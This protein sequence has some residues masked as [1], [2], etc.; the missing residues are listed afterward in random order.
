MVLA[1]YEIR[2]IVYK[3]SG[4]NSQHQPTKKKK[5]ITIIGRY[6]EVTY[7]WYDNNNHMV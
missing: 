2:S 6:I 3:D 7:A 5:K 1:T 4:R